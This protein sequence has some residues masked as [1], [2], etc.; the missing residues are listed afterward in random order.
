MELK[1][2]NLNELVEALASDAPTPDGGSA[3]ALTGAV[4]VALIEMVTKLTLGREKYK[5]HENL[6]LGAATHAAE[7]RVSLI[8]AMDKAA[9][10]YNAVTD[11][12]SMPKS[13]DDEKAT[14]REAMQRALKA[15]VEPPFEIMVLGLAA[16]ECVDKLL[17]RSNVNTISDLGVSALNLKAAVQGAWLNVLINLSGIT[18]KKFTVEYRKRGAEILKSGIALA[19][20]I[21][22]D[23]LY[24]IEDS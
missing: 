24:G 20:K 4:G 17:G 6:V 5:E 22:A 3:S 11:I 21:F 14:R 7:L 12:F 16:L 18:D 10:S 23:V 19:D 1:L 8:A 2:Y 9:A 13:T 15:A